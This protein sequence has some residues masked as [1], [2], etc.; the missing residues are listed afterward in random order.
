MALSWYEF[1]RGTMTDSLDP[2]EQ[3][4]K[5]R[6]GLDAF[7]PWQREAID[8]LLGQPGRVLVVR[9]PAGENP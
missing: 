6:F 7:R 8:A 1:P 9:R 4:L 3:V 2:I 5:S